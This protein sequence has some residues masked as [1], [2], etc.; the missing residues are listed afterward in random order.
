M[1][2]EFDDNGKFFTDI[3]SK[4]PTPVMIQ[5]ATHRI[6]ANIHVSQDRRLKDELNLPEKFIAITDTVIY[7]P[8]GQ[9]R[10][11]TNFL[12]VQRD[13]IIWVVP[14]SEIADPSKGSAE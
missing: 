2:I 1:T 13:E 8:D 3:I 11:Q 9:I 10:H 6:H 4:A 5:T 14:D 12:V 7:L